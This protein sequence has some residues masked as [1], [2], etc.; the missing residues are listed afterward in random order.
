MAE[1]HDFGQYSAKPVLADVWPTIDRLRLALRHTFGHVTSDMYIGVS[2][3][4]FG[5]AVSV[6][7]H[8]WAKLSID[9]YMLLNR[10]CIAAF[11]HNSAS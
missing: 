5:H 1:V 4:D 6:F 2:A 11:S 7:G 8:Y 9:N 10:L 3:I